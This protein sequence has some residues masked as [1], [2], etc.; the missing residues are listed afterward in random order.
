MGNSLLDVAAVRRYLSGRVLVEME[1]GEDSVALTFDDGPHPRYTPGLLDLLAERG[2][3][4]T[5]FLVGR[6][7]RTFPS[8]V[9][10]MAGEGH[11]VANH[12]DHH[13]PIT[14][15][16]APLLRREVR[17]AARAITEAAGSAPRFF[18]PPM[19]WIN[20]AALRT[21][22]ALGYRPVIGSIHPRDFTRPGVERIVEHVT[23]RVRPG[24][25]V[26]LH[27]GGA[28]LSVDRSQTVAAVSR[29]I[30]EL[31]GRGY[32]FRTLSGPA[33]APA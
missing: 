19:G 18:R 32:R 15:L 24:S 17:A 5:F 29:L 11:E 16:P 27:D 1:T 3:P 23:A 21:V 28:R 14:V 25:I 9:R 30:D 7:V 13:I 31:S 26:I 33:E 4:A 22:R 12:G 10:R 20:D 8:L 6:R 2:V